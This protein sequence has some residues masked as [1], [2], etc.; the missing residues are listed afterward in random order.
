VQRRAVVGGL[1]AG[2]ARSGLGGPILFLGGP[3]RGAR[4]RQAAAHGL[5]GGRPEGVATVFFTEARAGAGRP[6]DF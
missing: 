5:C 1:R 3:G 6:S 2:C 4:R